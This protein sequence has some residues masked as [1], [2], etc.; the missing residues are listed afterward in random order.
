MSLV[1]VVVPVGILLS[2]V[3][4]VLQNQTPMIALVFL[5]MQLPPLPLGLLMVA[6]GV[7]GAILGFLLRV[8]L[9]V[10]TITTPRQP[11]SAPR[12]RSHSATQ[13]TSQPRDWETQVT[14]PD[15]GV[16]TETPS[17]WGNKTTSQ[18]DKASI[19]PEWQRVVEQRAESQAGVAPSASSDVQDRSGMGRGERSFSSSDPSAADPF[20]Y[21]DPRFSGKTGQKGSVFDAEYRVL[22]PPYRSPDPRQDPL[23]DFDDEFF[24]E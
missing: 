5:G 3:A 14:D 22:T 8:L 15:W 7:L 20:R 12:R 24:N 2:L 6:G 10:A 13:T 21:R 9:E 4:I 16:D 18:A 23:D 19:P 17:D 11:Q 1:R